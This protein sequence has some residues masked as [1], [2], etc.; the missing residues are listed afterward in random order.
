MTIN[1]DRSVTMTVSN[2]TGGETQ[3]TIHGYRVAT[4]G[5]PSLAIFVHDK[6]GIGKMAI[7]EPPQVA[8]LLEQIVYM[9]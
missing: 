5:T 8:R 2:A 4:C 9:M 1:P 6:H 7:L 3:I